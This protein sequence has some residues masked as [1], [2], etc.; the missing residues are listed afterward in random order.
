MSFSFSVA[1]KIA[2]AKRHL[3]AA[4]AN[5]VGDTSQLRAA[6]AFCQAELAAWPES[7]WFNGV[8]VEANGHHDSNGRNVS[9]TI[10]GLHLAEPESE[11][12]AP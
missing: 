12:S 7:A 9:I 1:G 5:Y 6:R 11:Q 3:E 8:L 10:R 4:G 2:D